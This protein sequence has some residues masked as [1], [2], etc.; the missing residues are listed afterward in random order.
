M[1]IISLV[2]KHVFAVA[3]FGRPVLENALLADSV[4]G[5]QPLPEGRA[6]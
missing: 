6:H 4:F 3:T 2:E 1:L 5:A